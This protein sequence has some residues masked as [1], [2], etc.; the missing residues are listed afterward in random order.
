MIL[1]YTHRELSMLPIGNNYLLPNNILYSSLT[2]D[3]VIQTTIAW[4]QMAKLLNAYWKST[5]QSEHDTILIKYVYEGYGDYYP[6]EMEIKLTRFKHE[7]AEPNP[8]AI[9]DGWP[10]LQLDILQSH[11][12]LFRELL[13][14]KVLPEFIKTKQLAR[15]YDV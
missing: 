7:P 2:D 13:D 4:F 9:P 6:F 1:S 5:E 14:L 3:E 12:E 11:S 10:I 8:R 15:Y